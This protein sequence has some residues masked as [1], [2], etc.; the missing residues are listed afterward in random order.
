MQRISSRSIS[1]IPPAEHACFS[2]LEKGKA[3]FCGAAYPTEDSRSAAA[4]P[5]ALEICGDSFLRRPALMD[6]A[7]T[8]ILSFASEGLFIMQDPEKHFRCAAAFLFLCKGAGRVVTAGN[9]LAL[10]YRDGRINARFRFP[11]NPPLG[12]GLHSA[13]EAS[14]EFELSAGTNAFLLLCG[15]EGSDLEALIPPALKAPGTAD[16]AWAEKIMDAVRGQRCTAGAVMIP[17]RK[18]FLGL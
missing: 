14:A 11:K 8:N 5:K 6:V 15:E 18:G 12:S 16:E 17:E 9:A 1:D 3:A 10:H 2:F 7:M 4:C 13:Y